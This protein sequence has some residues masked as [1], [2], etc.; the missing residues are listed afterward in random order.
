MAQAAGVSH[1]SVQR[2]WAAHGLKPHRVRTFKLSNDPKSLPPRCRM[3]SG[4]ISTHPSLSPG[5]SASVISTTR[6]I[7]AAVSGGLPGG[8]VASC[9][10][11]ANPWAMKRACQRQIV[12]LPL[13]V[14]RW[15]SPSCRPYRRSAAQSAPATHASAGC[16]HTAR[17]SAYRSQFVV[18]AYPWHPLHGQRVRVYGRQGRAGRQILYIEVQPGLSRE[19][20]AW[21]CDGAVCAAIT[22]GSPRIAVAGLTELI[23][24]PSERDSRSR[25][26]N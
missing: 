17:H 18:V 21:M 26:T 15:I 8:R 19:L 14:C 2:I 10:K 1:R 12:G 4:S 13:P 16:S 6:S 9:S 24:S 22:L 7:T 20:P 25:F 11:P 23:P 3:S 5:G